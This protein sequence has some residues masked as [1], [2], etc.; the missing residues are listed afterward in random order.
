M[1]DIRSSLQE[2]VGLASQSYNN[3]KEIDQVISSINRQIHEF[4]GG[5]LEMIVRKREFGE[6]SSDDL[7]YRCE[8]VVELKV[9]DEAHRIASF[10][11][12]KMGYP[13]S[14]VFGGGA[15]QALDQEALGL[16][17][18]D[19]LKTHKVGTIIYSSMS[20]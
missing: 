1:I 17:F 5:K 14:L 9:G 19:L 16:A 15:I 7:K 4:T 11:R 10:G 2:A 20:K 13:C 18:S 8:D 12:S 6:I 3:N